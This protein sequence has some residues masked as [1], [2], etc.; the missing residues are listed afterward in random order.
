[1]NQK[2]F[3]S[4]ICPVFNEAQYI[5]S[6]MDSILQQDYGH[7]RIEVLLVDG[8]STDGT[9]SKINNYCLKY[10][11]VK[12]LENHKKIVPCA[13]NMGILESKGDYIIRLDAHSF[14]PGNYVSRLLDYAEKL[15]SDNVG[16]V[17]IT[18]VKNRN[19]KSLAIK[20]VLSNRLGVGNS[21]FRIGVKNITEVDTVVFGCFKRDVF[22]RFGY[23]D[24]RLVRNQ[25]IELNKRIK[26]GGGKLFLVPEIQCT[27]F[28]RETFIGLIKN[29][30]QNGLWNILTI[31]Y[32]K[33]MDSLSL[34]HF[35]PLLF[36]ISLIVPP[37]LA[38]GYFPIIIIALVSL[39][40]YFLIMLVNSIYLSIKKNIS[41]FYL[42]VS[43][44]L[45]HLSYGLGSMIGIL[46]L[47]V[48]KLSG[49]H[50]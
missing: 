18:E 30:F 31:Y 26:R 46:K 38:A 12:V 49:N 8:I 43:F 20:E 2:P 4:V 33:T 28:A 3:V 27:Y 22:E 16:G 44:F 35:I 9:R 36:V 13:M 19:K 25:D 48:L 29:N 34:R 10:P 17:C 40:L 32:T 39:L 5:D 14:Y 21:H 7:D 42:F 6:F 47:S 45:L 41:F 37:I 23:Y 11:F 50:L 24:E 15:N 1:M